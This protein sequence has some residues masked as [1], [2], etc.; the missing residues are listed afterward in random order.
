MATSHMQKSIRWRRSGKIDTPNAMRNRAVASEA[1]TAETVGPRLRFA[2]L[3]GGF[4]AEGKVDLYSCCVVVTDPIKTNVFVACD[5]I[6]R[7]LYRVLAKRGIISSVSILSCQS[8][9]DHPSCH[10]SNPISYMLVQT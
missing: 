5:Q 4:M 2:Q 1:T 8:P 9:S 7:E 3:L 6:K 10:C